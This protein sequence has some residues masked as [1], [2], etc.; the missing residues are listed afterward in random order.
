[1]ADTTSWITVADTA[2]KVGLGTLIGGGISIIA[3]YFSQR[4]ES[5]KQYN[6]KK[7]EQ[8]LEITLQFDKFTSALATY[9]A[10]VRNAAYK[11]ENHKT[12]AP[13]DRLSKKERAVI[14]KTETILFE[15]FTIIS[16]CKAR[17]LLGDKES[18]KR[19]HKFGELANTV[20]AESHIDNDKTTQKNLDDLKRNSKR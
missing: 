14:S 18:S 16:Q 1:V 6:D 20:F 13:K 7:R 15:S 10:N 2:V 9:W 8:L 3:T 5:T 19:L 11:K 17:L 4:R 12:L